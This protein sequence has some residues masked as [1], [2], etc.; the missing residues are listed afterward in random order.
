MS[1]NIN[2]K[3]IDGN[4]PVQG[5]NNSSQGFR[6]N[7]LAIQQG[8]VTASNEISKWKSPVS[9]SP[10]SSFFE[11]LKSTVVTKWYP[12][13]IASK[14]GIHLFAVKSGFWSG[15]KTSVTGRSL[16]HWGKEILSGF[17]CVLI[18]FIFAIFL[19]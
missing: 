14:R 16:Y 19:I 13:V 18:L 8:F 3:S 6:D 5:Q 4:Y 9:F 12:V 1:S 2:Y 7:F 17:K 11:K 15:N 10:V